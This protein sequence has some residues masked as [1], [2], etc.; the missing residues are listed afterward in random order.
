MV[1]AHN[2]GRFLGRLDVPFDSAGIPV[3]WGGAPIFIG[4][5]ATV[6]G[7]LDELAAPLDEFTSTINGET[8]L[9]LDGERLTV[10]NAE[11]NLG[12]LITDAMLWATRSDGTMIALQNGGGIRAS[13]TPGEI[14][15]A[16]VLTVLPFGN[17]M[18]QFDLSGVD[19]IA[20]LENGVSEIDLENPGESGGRW[21]HVAGLQISIDLTQEPGSRITLVEVR[22]ADGS[23]EPIDSE[24]TYRLVTNNFLFDG[25]DGYDMFAQGTNVRGGDILLSEA[26]TNYITE[27]SPLNSEVE[28]RLLIATP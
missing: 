15:L 23:F 26:V 12:N 22:S 6:A 2:W 19:I 11:S 27:K 16:Q 13:I 25:G 20:A 28:G 18:T 7:V 4:E 21:P 5:Q 8:E 9:F 17:R 3:S 14:S 1:H 10:R 24:A